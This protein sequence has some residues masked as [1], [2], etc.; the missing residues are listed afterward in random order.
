MLAFDKN[1]P[2]LFLI[3]NRPNETKRVFDSIRKA[4]PNRLYIAADGP[5]NEEEKQVCFITRSI[6]E[7]VDWECEVIKNFRETNLGCKIA[8]SEAISW[9]FEQ[10]EY[11]IVLEDDCLPAESFFGFCSQ[12]LIRYKDDERIGH[13][14]GINFQHSIQRGDSSYYFS[15]LTHI[16][17]WAGWRRVWKNYDIN[18]SSFSSF[19]KLD[20]IHQLNSHAPF[21]QHW[22]HVFKEVN[23]GEINTWDYQYAYLNLIN[24]MLCI[25]PNKNLISNIGVGSSATHT[26][27][28][29]FQNLPL[30]EM[31]TIIHPA[32]FV[33]DATADNYSQ[34]IEYN[35]VEPPPKKSFFKKVKEL[36][37][38]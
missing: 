7:K 28:H 15:R 11:G 37:K 26:I 5:R 38:I 25:I 34:K 3:F 20:I 18:I 35:I 2:V 36:F 29:P 1:T 17:G 33:A 10:E 19:E 8:V 27:S 12:L 13:I 32:F 4:A 16:W 22:L 24:N 14:A 23:R 30:E 31:S 21:A 9:F 6:A